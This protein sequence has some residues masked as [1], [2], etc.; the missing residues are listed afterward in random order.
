MG[1]VL[2]RKGSSRKPDDLAGLG[3]IQPDLARA[4][5]PPRNVT[6][7]DTRRTVD[8]G[9]LAI[10]EV[11]QAIAHCLDQLAESTFV[12]SPEK[13]GLDLT[14]TGMGRFRTR[15]QMPTA[16]LEIQHQK[17]DLECRISGNYAIIF[18]YHYSRII[19]FFDLATICFDN[20][21]L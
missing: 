4:Y 5:S 9:L 15:W 11:G 21:Q 12:V 1:R 8:R 18:L 13:T 10:L 3:T 17:Q 16:D 6:L 7:P 2:F 14:S 19:S 20:V